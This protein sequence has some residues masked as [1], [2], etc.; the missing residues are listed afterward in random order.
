MVTAD[1]PAEKPS[2]G[3]GSITLG[4]LLASFLKLGSI[5]FGGGMAV[6]ALMEEEFV[7]KRQI[8]GAEEFVHGVGLA[9]ILGPF[10]VNTS[11][12]IGYRLFGVMAG[13]LSA[14]AFLAPSVALVILLSRLYFRYH[15]IPALQGAVAGLG[16]VVIA[17]IMTAGW[18]IGR[19]V[20]RSWPEALIATGALIAGA[21]KLNTLWVL[22]TAAAAGF[23]FMRQLPPSTE[24]KPPQQSKAALLMIPAASSLTASV[25]TIAI[26]F[27]KI[28]LVFFGGGF[29]LV[30]LLHDRLVTQLGW[31]SSR[32][33]LDGMAISNLT[34]G[35][36]AV[37]ATFAGYHLAG[38]SG[39]LTATA[40][41]F[42][43]AM[44]LMLVISHGYERFREDRRVKRF[45]SG[46]NPAVAGL[47][48]SAALLLGRG[49]LVGW[50]GYLLLGLS[51]FL[52]AR[53][54]W[55][56]A[57]VLGIGAVAGYLGLLS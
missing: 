6:I 17:L 29:V 40:A 36:I 3:P 12:F 11:F 1:I 23:L 43:P 16:P 25:G 49:A 8:I 53:L 44:V 5:G 27:L 34:P 38:V 48:V 18:S 51:V 39:A 30:P 19:K 45:L 37:L 4:R 28:G 24:P 50:P 46:V 26:T 21:A 33:F 47:I 42:A 14:S 54:H 56:P 52:L 57:F 15:S 22:A 41:L 20:V 35:P 55:H 32:E 7:Q 9:Q 10:A 31:L 13:L 2:S